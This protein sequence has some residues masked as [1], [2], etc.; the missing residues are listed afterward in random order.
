MLCFLELT[1]TPVSSSLL[2]SSAERELLRQHIDKA[3]EESLMNDKEKSEQREEE[4]SEESDE[5]RLLALM[6]E[7]ESRVSE[8]PNLIDPHITIYVRHPTLGTKVRLFSPNA[9]FCEVYDWI[10]SLSTRPEFFSIKGLHGKKYHS[11]FQC[12]FWDV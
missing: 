4:K 6:K 2:G 8:E 3:F 9:T 10:G 5:G 1:S 12:I 7:R 11:R